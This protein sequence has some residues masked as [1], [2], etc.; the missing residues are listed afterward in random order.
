[1]LCLVS[2]STKTV[3]RLAEKGQR[4]LGVLLTPANGNA[5]RSVLSLGLP[6]AVDNGAFS[7]FD[8]VAFEK[9]LIELEHADRMPMWVACPDVVGDAVATYSMWQRWHG[10]I[11]GRGLPVAYVLQDGQDE[12]SMPPWP[13]LSAV[14]IGGSTD[15]KLGPAAAEL[16]ERAK[17]MRKLVHMGRVNSKARME[18]AW[19]IG[20][21]SIDG[22]SM[23]MF[24]DA[25]VQKF[26]DHAVFL[27]E[28]GSLFRCRS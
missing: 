13:F 3:R 26:C 18:L 5:V 10:K 4:N 22:T 19:H 6:Y 27:E 24:G 25:H 21:D 17:R 9:L 11:A 20:C 1:M 2:G 8:P 7:G 28:A 23:S 15:F 14:F 16:V 12:I